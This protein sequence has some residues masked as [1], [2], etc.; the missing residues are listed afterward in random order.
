M[1]VFGGRDYAT[2]FLD[3]AGN[4]YSPNFAKVAEAFGGHGERVTKG[5]EVGPALRR[6]LRAGKPALVECITSSEFPDDG[7]PAVGWWD[8]PVPAYLSE[9]RRRYEAERN[10][11]Y[12]A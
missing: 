12:L 11:E 3:R 10:E 8:V 4:R 2:E 5:P 1:A 6:A 9:R 7:S